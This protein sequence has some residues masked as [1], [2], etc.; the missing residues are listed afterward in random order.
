MYLRAV[1]PVAEQPAGVFVLSSHTENILLGSDIDLKLCV[2]SSVRL[3][4]RR[5]DILKT[6]EN[7]LE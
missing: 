7:D 1:A 4:K 3:H 2:V 5:D 6:E